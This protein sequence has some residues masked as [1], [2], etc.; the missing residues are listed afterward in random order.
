MSELKVAVYGV[1]GVGGYFGAVLARAGN[2]VSLI[3]R[4]AHLQA[5]REKGL[6]IQTPKEEFTI[7]PAAASDNPADIGPVDIV[8]VG[9]KAWQVPAAAKA[10][11]PLVKP[12]TR[13]VPLQ[14]GVEA[15]DDLVQVLGREHVL[16][17]LCR[18]IASIAAPGVIKIGGMEPIV[19]LGELDGSE[20]AGNAR[21]LLEAFRAAGV[22]VKAVPDIQSALWEKLLFITAVSGVGAVSRANVGEVR[23]SPPTRAL[24]QQVMEEV[25]AV[26]RRRGVRLADD[27]VTRTMAFID[28][29]PKEGTASMQ[30]DVA[31][32]RPSE[33][34]AIIGSVVRFGMA[35]GVPSPATQFIYASLL[36][37][38]ARARS[39]H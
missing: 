26:A 32:G 6:R 9:V 31:D 24:L 25:A 36:P 34:E 23:Q 37:Q 28:T 16:G 21:A 7:T 13:V 29:M 22:N 20:L 27:I 39:G 19:V 3:A 14:N 30:R 10:M 11:R 38:E 2:P 1:G 15:V 18:I 35:G 33:L 12:N 8:L 4:G 5:I 17:G